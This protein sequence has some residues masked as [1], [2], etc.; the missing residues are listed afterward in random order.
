MTD[1]YRKIIKLIKFV[2]L[3]K[4]KIFIS[5]YSTENKK[6]IKYVSTVYNIGKTINN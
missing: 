3:M 2:L 1:L 5:K 6:K 4:L